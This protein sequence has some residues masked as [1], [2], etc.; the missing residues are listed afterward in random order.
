MF[1]NYGKK[2]GRGLSAKCAYLQGLRNTW[3]RNQASNDREPLYRN[4]EN[5]NYFRALPLSWSLE[6]I[7]AAGKRPVTRSIII[8]IVLFF[9]VCVCVGVEYLKCQ[10]LWLQK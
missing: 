6:K 9:C 7:F 3:G 4:I 8:I 1:D 10:E 5:I 2:W